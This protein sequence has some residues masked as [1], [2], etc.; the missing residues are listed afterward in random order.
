MRKSISHLYATNFC[1]FMNKNNKV[2]IFLKKLFT[3]MDGE[4]D[5]DF[6]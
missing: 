3:N 5:M 1:C 6:G 2:T 4:P